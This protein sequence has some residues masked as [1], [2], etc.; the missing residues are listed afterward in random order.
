VSSQ[1][2]EAREPQPIPLFLQF[3]IHP[4]E[5]GLICDLLLGL[6]CGFGEL[7]EHSFDLLAGSLELE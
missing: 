5:L 3:V 2:E 7:E 6:L 1:D 4:Y